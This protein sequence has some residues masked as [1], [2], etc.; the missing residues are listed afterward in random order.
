MPRLLWRGI[1]IGQPVVGGPLE[2]GALPEPSSP[3]GEPLSSSSIVFV[4]TLG[5]LSWRMT[6]ARPLPRLSCRGGFCLCDIVNPSERCD[7]LIVGVVDYREHA[8]G[9]RA[10]ACFASVCRFELDNVARSRHAT[11]ER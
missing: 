3:H 9:H 5:L 6:G 1:V 7:L 8:L 4:P 2:P 11:V 10:F